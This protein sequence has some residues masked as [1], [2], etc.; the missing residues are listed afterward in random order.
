MGRFS[1]ANAPITEAGTFPTPQPQAR[2]HS[3]SSSVLCPSD[4][5][6]HCNTQPPSTTI[7]FQSNNTS[8]STSSMLNGAET[9]LR[10]GTSVSSLTSSSTRIQRAPHSISDETYDQKEVYAF[11]DDATR[12]NSIRPHSGPTTSQYWTGGHLPMQT[13]NQPSDVDHLASH[14]LTSSPVWTVPVTNSSHPPINLYKPRPSTA[15]SIESQGLSVMLPPKRELPFTKPLSKSSS[16]ASKTTTGMAEAPSPA[17]P[18]KEDHGFRP[19]PSMPSH[20]HEL[21][22]QS[23]PPK[24]KPKRALA[25]KAPARVTKKPAVPQSRKKAASIRSVSPVPG[26]EDLLRRS[27]EPAKG[28]KSMSKTI[29]TQVLLAHVEERQAIATNQG[30]VEKCSLAP[31]FAQAATVTERQDLRTLPLEVP[32]RMGQA[33]DSS[34]L[35]E[36][37]SQAE[38]VL[39]ATAVLESHLV[40][41]RE[42]QMVPTVTQ[43]TPSG[44]P[45]ANSDPNA[46]RCEL[47]ELPQ[48]T[49]PTLCKPSVQPLANPL[50]SPLA[51]LLQDADFAGS[52]NLAQWAKEPEEERRASLET[53]ICRSLQDENF[54]QLCKD[55]DGTW[56]RVFLGK[57]V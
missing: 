48:N 5:A 53:F 15:P 6:S 45:T 37:E 31:S 40:G 42:V 19:S 13:S 20:S 4:S 56:Q 33:L 49:A 36:P 46:V 3:S 22:T 12:A 38:N 57:V 23:A 28:V 7:A 26:V 35:K 50:P 52:P 34:L 25:K 1:E 10:P 9:F 2:P 21:E 43:G 27:Q 39:S 16:K 47:S 29:D 54:L 18:P 51:S 24:A 17:L 8:A 14:R 55:L 32:S 30:L 44:S 41:N 11:P